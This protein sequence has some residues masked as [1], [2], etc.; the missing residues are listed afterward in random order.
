MVTIDG[1]VLS[2]VVLLFMRKGQS[3]PRKGLRFGSRDF[4]TGGL[5]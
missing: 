4:V 3:F 2:D 1:L 5:K